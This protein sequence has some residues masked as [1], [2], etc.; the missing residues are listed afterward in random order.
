MSYIFTEDWFSIN[1]KSWTELLSHFKGKECHVLEIGSYQGRSAVWLLENILTHPSSKITCIDTFEGSVEHSHA[2]KQNISELFEANVI[3]NFGNKV[4]V[5]K[6]RSADVLRTL[7]TTKTYDFV[8]VDGAH[9]SANAMEDAVLSFPLLRVG[10]IM[11]FDDFQG[12]EPGER[13][14]PKNPY[15]GIV[16]FVS[17]YSPFVDVIHVGYQLALR[18]TASL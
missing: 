8:Y 2:Q 11:I 7:P 18:K 13:D 15:T 4:I 10:G 6:G 9:L 17:A 5:H 3:R 14:H 12:G 1:I 16:G